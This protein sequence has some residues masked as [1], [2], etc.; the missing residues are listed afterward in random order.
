MPLVDSW[1]SGSSRYGVLLLLRRRTR[2]PSPLN[3][4][5]LPSPPPHPSG[6]SAGVRFCF[7]HFL[8]SVPYLLSEVVVAP[9]SSGGAAA[10]AAGVSSSH[11]ATACLPRP[12]LMLKSPPTTCRAAH[13]PAPVPR[14]SSP[15][16]QLGQ[17]CWE[18]ASAH[19]SEP[20]PTP[21]EQKRRRDR[22]G[23]PH[24]GPSPHPHPPFCTPLKF[25]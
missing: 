7:C 9:P 13:T 22:N 15:G 17:A 23:C 21:G 20:C 10:A 16:M 3:V 5:M 24:L 4:C 19:A 18:R 1:A 25:S 2:S 6:P 12:C 8:P 14:L 11:P